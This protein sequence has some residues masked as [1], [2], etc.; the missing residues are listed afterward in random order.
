MKTSPEVFDYTLSA[1]S[2]LREI[3]VTGIPRDENSRV[4]PGNGRVL[5]TLV[6][7][8]NSPIILTVSSADYSSR[9]KPG[10]SPDG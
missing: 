10:S 8:Q 2:G 4:S 1:G 3:T 7:G 6:E 5:K 9:D